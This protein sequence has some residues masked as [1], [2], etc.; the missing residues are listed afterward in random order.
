MVPKS[1]TSEASQLLIKG[2]DQGKQII[3]TSIKGK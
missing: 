1:Q 2:A 3:K